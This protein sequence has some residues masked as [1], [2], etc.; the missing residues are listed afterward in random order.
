MTSPQQVYRDGGE[1]KQR[2][3]RLF[4]PALADA[5]DGTR[6]GP[7]DIPTCD[8]CDTRK[9]LGRAG[10]RPICGTCVGLLPVGARG[11]LVR[12]ADA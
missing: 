6:M 11:N 9:S 8:F 10:D 5:L 2:N 3:L 4:W 12:R 1:A 7:A